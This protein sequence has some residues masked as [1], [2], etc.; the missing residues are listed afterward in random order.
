[1]TKVLVYLRKGVAVV[2]GLLTIAAFTGFFYPI[3]F[4]DIQFVALTQRV[5]IDF[6]VIAAIWLGVLAVLTCL[7]GRIYCS[8]LCPLGILQQ[9]VFLIFRHKKREYIS[10]KPYKYFWSA[11]VFGTLLGGTALFIRYLDPY[12]LFGSALSRAWFGGVAVGAIILLTA[13]KKRFFCTNICPVGVVL[14]LLSRKAVN[15]IYI[16][17]KSCVSCGQ[18]SV[19]CPSSCIDFKNKKV[20]N[21]T[22]VKCLNCLTVCPKKS[23]HFG[24]KKV[25]HVPFSMTRRQ[26]IIGGAALAIFGAAAKNG[27]EFSKSVA[28]KAKR[29][30]LPAGAGNAGDF[31]NKC[32]NCNL[33]VQNCPM[34]IIK[35]ADADYSTVHLDYGDSFCDYSC[36]KCSEVCPSGAIRKITLAE[37]QETQLGVAV[38]D[39]NVCI[40][41]GLCVHAC[42]RKII[43]KED[44]AC[45][46]IGADKCIGCGACQAACPVKAIKIYPA[47][48]QR[49]I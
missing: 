28:A 45:P 41:C 44:G 48:G 16:D 26:L 34:K 43:S 10:N 15:K 30:L 37:K 47:A 35:K 12:T 5:M 23:L 39:E 3:P 31:A 21:E 46:D 24:I 27:I 25:A 7:F 49:R 1:M 36:H 2:V 4:L 18:C 38:L 29:V 9:A 22:C 14:G 8:L 40:K 32:L 11:F 19:K 42:P 6:S 13:F 17:E 20:D 33:C